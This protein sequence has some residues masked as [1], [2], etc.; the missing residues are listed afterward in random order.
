VLPRAVLAVAAVAV[1]VWLAVA[2]RSSELQRDGLA[3]ALTSE[4]TPALDRAL[5]DLR[6]SRAGVPDEQALTLEGAV[7][8]RAGRPVQAAAVFERLVRLEP[9]N[10]IAWLGLARS[11]PGARRRAEARAAIRRLVPAVR[12]SAPR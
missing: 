5:D 4:G 1:A 11:A 10:A 8:Q 3:L 9:E 2:L 12:H 6:R 7:L